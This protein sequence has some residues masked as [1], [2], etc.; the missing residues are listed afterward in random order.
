MRHIT[1][2]QFANGERHTDDELKRMS[3]GRL[4]RMFQHFRAI[5]NPCNWGPR[6]C[7]ICHEYIGS[8]YEKDVIIPSR[9]YAEYAERLKV[10][11][12]TRPDQFTHRQKKQVNKQPVTVKRR[13]KRNV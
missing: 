10:E 7:E 3:T 4:Y 11:L 6:C 1:H 9:P 13:R 2:Q 12:R 8:D 5:A